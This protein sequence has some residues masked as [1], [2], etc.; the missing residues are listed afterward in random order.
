MVFIL[1]LKTTEIEPKT[2]F[3]DFGLR[4]LTPYELHPNLP[5]LT[6]EGT[7]S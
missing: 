2:R 6:Y 1:F 3:E 5:N 7:Y 4:L